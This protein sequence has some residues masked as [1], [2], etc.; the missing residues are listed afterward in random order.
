MNTLILSGRDV[1]AAVKAEVAGEVKLLKEQGITPGLAV[2]L[3]GDDPASQVYVRNKQRTA[4]KLGFFSQTL[5]FSEDMTQAE[6]LNLIDEL[7]TDDRF[8]GILVQLP[9][10][11][12]L[13]EGEVIQRISPEKDV[14]GLHPMSV[15]KLVLNQ[16]TFVSC[17]PAGIIEI[18]KYYQINPAGKN[19]VIIG[20][21]NIVGKPVLNLLYQ[22][23]DWANA[24]VTLCHT[25]TKN[26]KAHTLQ[27]DIVI[28]AAG[29][30]K[31]LTADMVREDAI[32]V[33]VGINRID[34]PGSEKGQYLV[35][36]A[37]YEGLLDK[38]SAITPVPGGVGLM[39]IA[40]LMK[41][42]VKSAK[43]HVNRK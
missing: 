38:V 6:L 35:G 20:R 9:L 5:R 21:S 33:D 17:T 15:G 11:K 13:N 34:D 41:N 39:T 30:P 7:N 22:K 26:I 18:F 10:P 36:D 27:A 14:D 8:H 29:Q 28:V 3:V 31:M 19:I 37:D 25:Q 16:D 2:V 23:A 1:A 42:T 43:Q 12:H 40:M 4:E 24:T 32:V